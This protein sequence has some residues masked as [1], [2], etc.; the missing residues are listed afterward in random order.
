MIQ[1]HLRFYLQTSCRQ[2]KEGEGVYESMEILLKSME[3]L[4]I[5]TIKPSDKVRKLTLYYQE[6]S[7]ENQPNIGKS[8]K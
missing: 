5:E 1:T 7:R 2:V 3:I 6:L 4:H 8:K